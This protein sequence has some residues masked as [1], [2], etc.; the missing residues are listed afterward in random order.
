MR[1]DREKLLE[2]ARNVEERVLLARTLDRAE[3]VLRSGI[4]QFTDFY[5][6]YHTGLIIS[7]VRACPGL[8][9]TPWGGI[10]AAERVRTAVHEAGVEPVP[11]DYDIGFI[12][13]RG[14]F[15]MNRVTHRDFL[16]ALLGLGLKREKL[17]DILVAENGAAVAA[18]GDVLPYIRS[19]L[20]KVGKVRVS[21]EDISPEELRQTGAP[22]REVRATL[23]SLRL[24]AVAAA[25]YGTSRSR[26]VPEIQ[27][28]RFSV[29]WRPCRDPATPVR[30]G[31]LLS[32]RGRGRLKVAEVYGP[33]KSGRMSVVLHRFI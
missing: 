24:D 22:Y 2:R 1:I 7:T 8:A 30:E 13:I 16:G 12:F 21:V 25:G 20:D 23:P 19:G 3:I 17:G 27:A 28:E 5:D 31:D 26:L 6:P 32:A 15:K 10:P 9:A 33:L 29:N 11:E 14:N 18:A 4:I